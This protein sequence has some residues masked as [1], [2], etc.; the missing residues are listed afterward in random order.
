MTSITATASLLPCRRPLLLLLL[1]LRTTTTT[2]TTTQTTTITTTTT[3]TTTNA[4]PLPWFAAV[5]A[6][7]SL[8]RYLL[9]NNFYLL[10]TAA[11]SATTMISLGCHV[12]THLAAMCELTWLPCANSLGCHVRTHLTAMCAC[13]LASARLCPHP[14]NSNASVQTTHGGGST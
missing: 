7:H 2:T 14:C 4:S 11:A 13:A 12:R 8:A 10:P 5:R 6:N 3:T 9:P 1:L